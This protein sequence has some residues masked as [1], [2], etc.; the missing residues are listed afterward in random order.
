M[1]KLD[2]DTILDTPEL[3]STDTAAPPEDEHPKGIQDEPAPTD[4]D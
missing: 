3:P 1:I 4:A 2:K